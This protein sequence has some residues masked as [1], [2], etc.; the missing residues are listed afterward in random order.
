MARSPRRRIPLASV[1]G[2]LTIART[3]SGQRDLRRLD[4][5]HGRQDH[6]LLPSAASSAGTRRTAMCD[7]P[8]FPRKRLSA[9]SSARPAL[10]HGKHPPC[11][12]RSRPTLLRPPPPVPTFVTTADAP[13]CGTG[14]GSFSSDLPDDGSGNIFRARAGRVFPDL[15]VG[16]ECHS[17]RAR[18]SLRRQANQLV[19]C[20]D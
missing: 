19:V 14:C 10:A 4:A 5:S 16:S 9:G 8:T 17:D 1:A 2:G 11:E 18:N 3:R 13:L 12:H 6:T 15:P 20:A 7:G